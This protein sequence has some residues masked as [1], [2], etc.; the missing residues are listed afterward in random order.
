[1]GGRSNNHE[2]KW[3]AWERVA[4]PKE[5]GGMGFRN[6]KV[7]NLAMVAKQGWSFLSKPKSL[8]AKV[9]KIEVFSPFFIFGC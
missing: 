9:F 2:I 8:V 4:C 3:M 5:F 1:M 7:F 6:F